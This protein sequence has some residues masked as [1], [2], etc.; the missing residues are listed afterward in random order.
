MLK[1][2]SR[3]RPSVRF[4]G[5]VATQLFPRYTT[6]HPDQP[7]LNMI[8]PPMLGSAVLLGLLLWGLGIWF[9]LLAIFSI[10]AQFR[11]S[12]TTPEGKKTAVFNMGWWAFT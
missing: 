3:L 6:L 8:A 4:Q 2:V 12:T 1:D 5:I 11:E 10:A 9:A 7:Y